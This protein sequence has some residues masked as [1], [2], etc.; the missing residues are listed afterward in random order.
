MRPVLAQ[1]LPAGHDSQEERVPPRGSDLYVP[2]GHWIGL[3]DP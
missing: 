2:A 1:Y 3:P